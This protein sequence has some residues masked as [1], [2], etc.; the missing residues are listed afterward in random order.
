[1]HCSWNDKVKFV[2]KKFSLIVSAWNVWGF[3]TIPIVLIM[4]VGL[5]M[6]VHFVPG[7]EIGSIIFFGITIGALASGR[8]IEH[9][10]HLH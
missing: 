5:L 10:G 9:E 4:K 2:L 3:F 1:L 6:T 8:F 7:G